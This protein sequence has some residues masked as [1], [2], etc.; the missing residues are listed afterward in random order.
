VD[1]TSAN[2]RKSSYSGTESQCVEV[3]FGSERAAVRDSKDPTGG[4]LVLPRAAYA[5]LV[6]QAGVH[7]SRH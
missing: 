1:L 2:W 4:A 7:P 6:L 3:A 5:A